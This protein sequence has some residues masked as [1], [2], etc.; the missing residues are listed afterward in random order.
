MSLQGHSLD[1]SSLRIDWKRSNSSMP[2]G[3]HGY[4]D[5]GSGGGVGGGGRCRKAFGGRYGGRTAGGFGRSVTYPQGGEG[6]RNGYM[7]SS[8][9]NGGYSNGSEG[10]DKGTKT[11]IID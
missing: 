3:A 1:G 5:D 6:G 4:E 11:L 8:Y 9:G 2:P 10:V 7:T